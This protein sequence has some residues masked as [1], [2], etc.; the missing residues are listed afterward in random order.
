MMAGKMCGRHAYS[1]FRNQT[2]EFHDEATGV[3]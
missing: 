3:A 1:D 2:E